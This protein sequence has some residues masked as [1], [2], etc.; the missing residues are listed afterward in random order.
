MEFIPARVPNRIAGT[1]VWE[2]LNMIFKSR[3]GVWV[4]FSTVIFEGELFLRIL[5]GLLP[6]MFDFSS[7]IFRFHYE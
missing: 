3:N 2:I 5:F 7:R 1:L 4:V 6:L